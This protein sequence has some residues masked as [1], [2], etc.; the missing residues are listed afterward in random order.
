MLTSPVETSLTLMLTEGDPLCWSLWMEISLVK[1]VPHSLSGNSVSCGWFQVRLQSSSSHK[2]LAPCRSEKLLIL[3]LGFSPQ[4]TTSWPFWGIVQLPGSIE[5][6]CGWRF[7]GHQAAWQRHSGKHHPEAF[8]WL[9]PPQL[10]SKLAE[11]LSLMKTVQKLAWVS[12]KWVQWRS[13][14]WNTVWTVW[15]DQ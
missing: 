13:L 4:T 8:Q 12:C 3:S 5:R 9:K 2:A 10:L 11:P 6:S 15:F 1:P 7:G 14:K